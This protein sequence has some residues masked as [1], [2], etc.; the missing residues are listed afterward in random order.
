MSDEVVYRS[1]VHIER[2]KGPFRRVT[3]PVDDGPTY[4]GVHSEIA[5]HYGVDTDVVNPHNTTLD[6]VVASAAG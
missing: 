3:L 2:V 5:A 4:F 6:F 1:Q